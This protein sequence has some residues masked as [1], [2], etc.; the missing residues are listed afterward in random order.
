MNTLP[1]PPD[2]QARLSMLANAVPATRPD[3]APH[4]LEQAGHAEPSP[5]SPADP[6]KARASS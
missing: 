1:L 4:A 2:A 5:A 6:V 3:S